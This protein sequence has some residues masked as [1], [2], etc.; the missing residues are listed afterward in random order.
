MVF[1]VMA[2]YPLSKDYMYGRR[3]FSLLFLGTMLFTA[4][5]IPQYLLIRGLGLVN[6]YFAIWLPGLVGVYNLMVMKTFFESVSK[7]LEA[8][9]RIDGCS[10]WSIIWYVF[11]P[12]SK[13]VLAAMTLF[14]SVALWNT[15]KN[16]LIYIIDAEKHNLAVMVQHLIRS[17]TMTEE[18]QMMNQM[19]EVKIE[20]VPE[21]IKAAG[22][23]VMLV[24]LMLIYPWLQKYFVKG[25]M[26]GAIKS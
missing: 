6:S 14:Y 26:I 19:S 15:F 7:D 17:S 4:G 20:S 21:A 9:A 8:A 25:V 13:P 10:E 2:A 3:F 24:P 12:L 22:I 5:L 23:V 16:V 11:I 1:T 18:Q